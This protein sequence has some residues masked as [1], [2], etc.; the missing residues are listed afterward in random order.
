VRKLFD[1]ARAD[2]KKY[3]DE[4][5]LHVVVFD[6]IDAVCRQRGSDGGGSGNS[7]LT[8]VPKMLWSINF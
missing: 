2:E 4:S 6:E 3:G 7:T 8:Q 5:P 1:P